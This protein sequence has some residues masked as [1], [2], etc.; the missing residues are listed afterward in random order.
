MI[1][2]VFIFSMVLLIFGLVA[3]MS[4]IF[5]KIKFLYLIYAGLAALLFMFYLAID[6]QV[7]EYR[8]ITEN[9]EKP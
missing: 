2:Y 3:I 4:M 7:K 9:A 1:G 8:K 5:F 6:V